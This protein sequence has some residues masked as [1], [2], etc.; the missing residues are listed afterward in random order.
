MSKRNKRKPIIEKLNDVFGEELV[1][2]NVIRTC[3]KI[4]KERLEDDLRGTRQVVGQVKMWKQM[5]TRWGY[6]GISTRRIIERVF[7]LPVSE[8]VT[9]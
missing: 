3:V 1:N 7:S 5:K 8:G 2:P 4:L 6:D 9:E